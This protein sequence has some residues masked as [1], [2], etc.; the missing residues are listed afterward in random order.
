M[1]SCSEEMIFLAFFN[2]KFYVIKIGVRF[3]VYKTLLVG[4]SEN[5]FVGQSFLYIA[6]KSSGRAL[7][8]D[9]RL[10]YVAYDWDAFWN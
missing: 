3:H 4:G 2:C 10:D 9:F 6:A 7:N 5:T 8:P 1:F